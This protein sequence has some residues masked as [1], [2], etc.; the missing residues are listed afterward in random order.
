MR[1]ICATHGLRRVVMIGDGAT[2]LEARQQGGAEIFIGW[3]GGGWACMRG[4]V[5]G[6]VCVAGWVG[7][8]AWLGGRV[9]MGDG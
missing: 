2:D 3:V 9:H 7:L 1:H 4:W 6:L 8:H 5:G